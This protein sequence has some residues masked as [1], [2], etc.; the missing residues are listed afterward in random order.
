L[1]PFLRGC[2]WP[3]APGWPYPR[4]DPGPAGQRLPADTRAAAALPVGVRLEFVGD[5]EA[6]EI[7]YRT[8]TGE[9]GYR[10][11]GAGTRFSLLRGDRVVAEVEAALGE[12]RLRLPV[13]AGPEPAVVY[14]PEGMRPTVL[15]LRAL[16]GRLE[17]AP[18]AP[19]WL[20]YGDSIVE[21]WQ[22]S[23]PAW[24]W[25][26]RV[27]RA[28]ALD[29]VNLGYAGAARGE[30]ASAE[31]IAGLDAD[32]ITVAYGT[33]CWTRTPHG[34][35]LFAETLRAFLAVVRSGH[36]ETPIV[37]VSPILRLDAE[38][39][40]NRLGATL[41]DLRRVFERVV[42]ERIRAGDRALVLVEGEGLVPADE[43][44]DGI[45]PDDVGH[46]RLARCLAP[47][48]EAQRAAVS[49]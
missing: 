16:G 11:P 24:A 9:L 28:C 43:L 25:P 32:L 36:P 4:C 15:G 33:N 35:A 45:H 5:A 42:R 49:R 18:R 34:G 31:E 22:A 47:V 41:G 21:G 48:L 40:A 14:L 29:V 13:G 27:G 2:V 44:P 37:A 19:R 46:A 8:E 7:A 1:E 12:G 10:G 3:A 30:I 23:G 6:V 26:A 17:P 39:K 20:C 38:T